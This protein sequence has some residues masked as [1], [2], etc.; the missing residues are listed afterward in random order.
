M[1]ATLD[2]PICGREI[3][4]QPVARGRRWNVQQQ[5]FLHK[6][7]LVGFSKKGIARVMRTTPDAVH[8]QIERV[9]KRAQ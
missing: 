6:M 2:C 7:R 8:H 9:R 5:W 3:G 4:V 1:S